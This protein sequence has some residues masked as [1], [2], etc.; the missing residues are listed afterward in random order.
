MPIYS[1]SLVLSIEAT[2]EDEALKLFDQ[3]IVMG[4]YDFNNIDIDIEIEGVS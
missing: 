1:V 3:E 4:R 2:D